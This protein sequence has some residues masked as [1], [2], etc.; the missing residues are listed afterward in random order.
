[1]R[2]LL[3]ARLVLAIGAAFLLGGILGGLATSWV[4]ERFRGATDLATLAYIAFESEEAM[5][6]YRHPQSED[7]A[8]YA[9]EHLVRFNEAFFQAYLSG[10][11]DQKGLRLYEKAVPFDAVL[12]YVRLGSLYERKGMPE[13]ASGAFARAMEIASERKVFDRWRGSEREIRTID[14]LRGLVADLNK[15]AK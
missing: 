4:G 10:A 8:I 7:V 6:Q 1:M 13:K 2:E 11:D 5:K 12:M 3:S 14:D 15:V 9:L